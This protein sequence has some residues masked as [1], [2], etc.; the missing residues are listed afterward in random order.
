MRVSN[1]SRVKGFEEYF[2]KRNISNSMLSTTL[3]GLIHI[4]E[5]ISQNETT[6]T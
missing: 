6:D 3:V 2:L 5:S 1:L 4:I